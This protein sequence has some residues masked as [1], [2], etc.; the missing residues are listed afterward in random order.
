MDVGGDAIPDL[1]VHRDDCDADVGKTRWD[2]YTGSAA[3][4]A[5]SPAAF[6]I[7]APRCGVA[8]DDIARIG[9][10]LKY[11]LLDVTGD[12]LA[13]L[14]VHQDDCDASVGKTHWDVYAG[15][16]SGFSAAP[17]AF[18]LPAARCGVAWDELGRALGALEYVL[19]DM[20]GDGF[21]DLVVHQDDC[22][23]AIGQSRWDVYAG[24]ASGFAATPTGY[25]LPAARCGVQWD[26][27][28]RS[29]GSLRYYLLDLTGDHRSDLVVS[30]DACDTTV[31]QSRWDVYP[32]GAAGFA[33]GASPYAL[34]AARCATPWDATGKVSS[35][36]RYSLFDAS[37]DDYPDLVVTQ[38]G[39]DAAIGQ[40][41]WDV[42]SGSAAGFAQAPAGISVPAAR[43][44]TQ[45]DATSKVGSSLRFG[46][47]TW[48]PTD[49]LSLLVSADGC[50][51]TVGTA[52]WDYYLAK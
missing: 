22:E 52:H 6:S 49:H 23:T 24:S 12:E 5:P 4:L 8:F 15:S 33:P 39:C 51:A 37:C 46:M 47:M 25:A 2:V 9:G 42:Y 29:G 21:S 41:R 31:G 18:S 1:V 28:S 30:S 48:S 50:D 3:G 7:P 40:S 16:A 36:L 38:D 14:V 26:E 27:L 17:T 13:D 19:M 44:G 11:A 45:F 10:G 43:C 34:P 35:A 20:T 32:G